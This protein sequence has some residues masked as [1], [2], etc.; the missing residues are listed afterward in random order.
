MLGGGASIMGA[1]GGAADNLFVTKMPV[2]LTEPDIEEFFGAFGNVLSC[3][4]VS[5]PGQP[6]TSA[7]IR[8][9]C[10]EEAALVVKTL[11]GTIPDGMST[12]IEVTFAKHSMGSSTPQ[13]LAGAGAGM[14]QLLGGGM[15]MG[16]AMGMGMNPMAGTVAVK[17]QGKGNG[18]GKLGIDIMDVVLGAIIES[19]ALPG[20]TGTKDCPVH[21]VFIH[22]LPADC[23]TAHLYQLMSPFGQIGPRGLTVMSDKSNGNCIGYGFVNFLA[24]ESALLAISTLHDCV[25]PSGKRLK[26]S[27]KTAIDLQHPGDR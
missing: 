10:A 19:G 7:L 27:I 11:N 26:V 23:S 6:N 22:G 9:S 14:R 16:M 12:P 2:G 20:G 25:L 4:I 15:G 5:K 18:K 1:G 8:F 24:E 3:K 13:G 17:G 21:E